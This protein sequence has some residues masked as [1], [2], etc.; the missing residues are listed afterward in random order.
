MS[1]PRAYASIETAALEVRPVH[2]AIGIFD[3]VH[4]GHQ[5]VIETAVHS[6]RSCGGIAAVLTFRPHPSRLFRPDQPT[7]LL[8]PS[9][10][11][12]VLFGRLGVEAMITHPFTREFAAIPA[13]GFL[14]WLRG[15]LPRLA[16][17]YVGQNWRF[18]AGRKGDVALLVE[19]GRA[20]GIAV[21]SASA[22]QLD[23]EPVTST[24]IRGLLEA[25]QI[26][27]ANQLLGY[28]YFSSGRTVPGRQLARQLGYPTL[29]LPWNPELR[30]KHG[31]YQVTVEGVP[32]IANYG[33][34]PTVEAAGQPLLEVHVLGPCRWVSGDFLTVEWRRFLRE[35]RK[36]G[37]L[38][39]L[40]A[41]VARDVEDAL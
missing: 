13:E 25:G 2:L 19:S 16:G 40:K 3:G 38:A 35:E 37:S 12:A 9:E 22:V 34:R 31:V 4:L 30:P 15:H 24:R 36:F 10:A 26:A 6:A 17:V 7:R 11:Q 23:G 8:L 14:P 28:P 41:Q 39:E 33:V 20:A 21:F 32:G 1:L 18:G 27:A 5:T 29:N